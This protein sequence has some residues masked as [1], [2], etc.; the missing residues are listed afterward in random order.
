MVGTAQRPSGEGR[1]FFFSD[2]TG[3]IDLNSRIDPTLGWQ[4][5]EAVAISEN[6]QIVGNGDL[7]AGDGLSG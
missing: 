6:G 7:T 2:A 3:M 5:Y 4:L 1:A